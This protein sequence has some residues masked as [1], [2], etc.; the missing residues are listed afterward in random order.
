MRRWPLAARLSAL[1]AGLTA[2]AA[3]AAAL[4]HSG[5]PLVLLGVS[6]LFALVSVFAAMPLRM[7]PAYGLLMSGLVS[8][9]VAT[10]LA[11][12]QLTAHAGIALAVAGALALGLAAWPGP[13]T[14]PPPERFSAA[15]PSSSS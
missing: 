10:Y 4:S 11:A 12:S 5:P 2:L 13:R 1:S 3:S 7:F 15:P 14:E 9:A 8:A 6:A